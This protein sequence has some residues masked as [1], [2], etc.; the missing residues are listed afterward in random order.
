MKENTKKLTIQISVN[1]IL[2]II[3]AILTYINYELLKESDFATK[4]FIAICVIIMIAVGIGIITQELASE[5]K[6][7]NNEND[8]T[9][10]EE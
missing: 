1:L 4:G 5:N 9:K 3:T 6:L 2:L 10:N 7:E 8:K